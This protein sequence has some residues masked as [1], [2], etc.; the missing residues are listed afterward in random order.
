MAKDIHRF[1]KELADYINRFI[2]GSDGSH[3]VK[4][5]EEDIL[6]NR[7]HAIP[8][9]CAIE[10][11]GKNN[12][13]LCFYAEE[14]MSEFPDSSAAAVAQ[15]V[16][17]RAEAYYESARKTMDIQKEM[18]GKNIRDIN[19]EDLYLSAVLDSDRGGL[20]DGFL[21]REHEGLGITTAIKV[22][23]GHPAN[24]N[25]ILLFPI[26]ADKDH[27]TTEEDWKRAETN[28]LKAAHISGYTMTVK[29]GE[30][31]ICG[32][33][34]DDKRFYDYFYLLTPDIWRPMAEQAKASKIYIF[35]YMAY[36]AKFV[37]E[38]HLTDHPGPHA[39]MRESFMQDAVAKM[40]ANNVFVLDCEMMTISKF[41]MEEV[42]G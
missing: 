33:I 17:E 6:M 37:V 36:A 4:C 10:G 18:E 11:D 31:P 42:S 16:A 23:F 29:D 38:N 39:K 7:G 2:A 20:E 12:M 1:I 3:I 32:E 8:V 19:P 30:P 25:Q 24:K 26:R 5:V 34:K 28:S 14:L 35:P 40:P 22:K 41:D 13:A 9:E 27:P 21:M 15:I